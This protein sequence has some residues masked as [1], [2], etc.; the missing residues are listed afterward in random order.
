M[1]KD[2]QPQQEQDSFSAQDEIIYKMASIIP[3]D[4]V[5]LT[6]SLFDKM[7]KEY[8]KELKEDSI[9]RLLPTAKKI[10]D[11]YE[12]FFSNDDNKLSDS[13]CQ[14]DYNQ[15]SKSKKENMNCL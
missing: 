8:A 11:F 14:L 5:Q 3:S 2:S 13:L 4:T 15:L 7:E 6:K 1:N 12:L 9:A 10:C